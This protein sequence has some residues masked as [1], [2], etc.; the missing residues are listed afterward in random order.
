MQSDTLNASG[1]AENHN[2]NFPASSSSNTFKFDW[3]N[4]LVKRPAKP[5][6]YMPIEILV[7]KIVPEHKIW[8]SHKLELTLANVFEEIPFEDGFFHPAEQILDEAI[9]SSHKREVL[10]WLLQTITNN[11]DSFFSLSVLRSLAHLRP[12]TPGWRVKIIS[13]ALSSEDIETRDVA[14]QVAESWDD[15]EVKDILKK[16][17][18]PIPWLQSYINEVI[19]NLGK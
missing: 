18:E 9:G 10:D 16:H 1:W 19:D 11:K 6:Y 17:R 4:H 7:K 12:A 5:H 3:F 8:D 14:A 2:I 15:M 13:S